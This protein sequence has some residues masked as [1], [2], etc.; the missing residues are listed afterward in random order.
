MSRIVVVGRTRNP[1]AAQVAAVRGATGTSIAEIKKMLQSGTPILERVLFLNDHD[2]S[3][4]TL[5]RLVAY[6]SRVAL[7]LEIFELSP[8]EVF[9]TV[10]QSECRIDE[11]ILENILS[12]RDT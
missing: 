5:R 1:T 11:T 12:E 10:R 4:A 6:A 9:E 7:P 2:E 8:S 3:A